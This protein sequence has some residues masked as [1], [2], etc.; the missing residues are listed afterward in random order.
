[1]GTKGRVNH[2]RRRRYYGARD[3]DLLKQRVKE[4]Y[5][6][7]FSQ[8]EIAR[9]MDIPRG[10]L[11]R[12]MTEDGFIGRDPGQMGKEKSKIYQYDENIF[13]NI[14]DPNLAYI[15]GFIMGDGCVHDRVKSKRLVIAIAITDRQIL[16][17]IADYL[18]M[19]ELLKI[20]KAKYENEQDKISLT[21]NSTKLCH[22]LMKYGVLPQK[23]GRECFPIFQGENLR[24]AFLRGFFDADG[25]IRRY[26]RSNLEKPKF[27]LTG[28]E[29]M[30]LQIKHFLIAHG[31]SIPKKPIYQKVGCVSFELASIKTIRLLATHLYA[32]NTGT[33]SLKRKQEIFLSFLNS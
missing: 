19:V 20:R 25:Y 18:G 1:M 16:E 22:D 14:N 4:F 6:E 23:T 27:T 24:W 29:K 32:P 26:Y 17:D 31:L 8:H 2:I 5:N 9:I 28:N 3:R 12:W 33:L 30:M 21:I 11:S 15:V 10:T 13:E 7:G